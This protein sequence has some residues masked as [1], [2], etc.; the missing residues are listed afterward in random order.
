MRLLKANIVGFTLLE[1]LIV[2]LIISI[3]AGTAMLSLSVNE[4]KQLEALTEELRQQIAF[5]RETAILENKILG[6]ALDEQQL[7]PLRY[8]T[9]L[10]KPAWVNFTLTTLRAKNFPA[11][12]RVQIHSKLAAQDNT[13]DDAAKEFAPKIIFS[14]NGDMSPFTLSVTKKNRAERFLIVGRADGYLATKGVVGE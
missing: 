6:V 14:I 9:E 1:I 7:I 8:N 5:I 13:E 4:R 3:V 12:V 11:D 2:L 10:S